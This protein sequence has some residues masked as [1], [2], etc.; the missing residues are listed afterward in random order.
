MKIKLLDSYWNDETKET[1]LIGATKY[2]IFTTH[3]KPAEE[4]AQYASW[5]IGGDIATIKL[6]IKALKEKKKITQA[7][8][9][10]AQHI[11]SIFKDSANHTAPKFLY[12]R[13]VELQAQIE[14]LKQDIAGLT[15]GIDRIG[16]A[17][18]NAAEH[19]QKMYNKNKD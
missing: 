10:E 13:I 9:K 12:S 18:A 8:L 4:D 11:L 7:Q 14:E 2:G 19:I 17:H 6:K 1:T 16:M 15:E 5:M 3:T